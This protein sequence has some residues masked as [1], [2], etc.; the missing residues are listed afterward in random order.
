MNTELGLKM[1]EAMRLMQAG[2]L[3]AATAA[4]QRGLQGAS[5]CRAGASGLWDQSAIRQFQLLSRAG[6][7]YGQD[8]GSSIIWGGRSPSMRHIE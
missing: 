8:P 4:I 6:G 5:R 2:D 1:S 7:P 3:L